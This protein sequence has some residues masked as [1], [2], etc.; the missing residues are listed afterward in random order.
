MIGMAVG[1]KDFLQRNPRPF[2]GR[3]STFGRERESNPFVGD[4][5]LAR[6]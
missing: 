2:H 6:G 4:A 3:P 1:E 5:V